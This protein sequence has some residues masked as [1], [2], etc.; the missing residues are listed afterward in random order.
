MQ[1]ERMVSINKKSSD[2]G[3][4][5]ERKY[6]VNYLDNS[7]D[8]S[9]TFSKVDWS[10]LGGSFSVLVV[11]LEDTTR[12]FTLASDNSTHGAIIWVCITII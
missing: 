9:M 6:S 1:Q 8:V 2:L 11:A 5:I 12:T 10:Q 7:L 3:Y 4:S